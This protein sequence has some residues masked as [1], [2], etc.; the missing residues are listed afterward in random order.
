MKAKKQKPNNKNNSIKITVE[1]K[2]CTLLISESNQRNREG[3]REDHEKQRDRPELFDRFQGTRDWRQNRRG[4]VR[5][6]VSGQ[7]AWQASGD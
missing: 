4:R 3:H 2:T 7:V 6:R 1:E 5:Y